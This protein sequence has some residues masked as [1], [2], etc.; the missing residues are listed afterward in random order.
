MK[1][2]PI[3]FSGPMVKAILAGRKTQTRRVIHGNPHIQKVEWLDNSPVYPPRWRGKEGEPYTGW[4]AKMDGL[5]IHLPRECPYGTK[6]DR[7]WIRENFYC[8]VE[9]DSEDRLDNLYYR[10]DGECCQVI[11]EC[12]CAEVGK[13]RWRPSIHMPRWASRLSL[14]VQAVR[15]ERLQQITHDDIDAEGSIFIISQKN[16][17]P[18]R[19]E[20]QAATQRSK[21][22]G[23]GWTWGVWANRWDS[24]NAGRGY[25]WLMNPWVWVVEFK[26]MEERGR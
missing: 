8:D 5:S 11:P 4:A 17:K 15:V 2:H 9:D 10:A 25:G 19:E 21:K 18:Y 16:G 14:E 23:R 13:V 1:E 24:I 20:T 26:R 22:I 7:L 6:L 12:S 3:L